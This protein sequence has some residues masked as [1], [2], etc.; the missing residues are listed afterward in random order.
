MTAR[1]QA[2]TLRDDPPVADL[3]RSAAAGDERAWE[4]IVARYSG[5]VW[6]MVRAHRLRESDAADAVATTWLRLVQHLPRIRQPEAVGAWLATTARRESLR[7]LQRDGR[8]R[9]TS[10]GDVPEISD[11]SANDPETQA[12]AND[13]DRVLWRCVNEL[14][15]R[16][17]ALMLMLTADPPATY[18]EVSDTLTMP[19]GSIGPTRARCLG[20]L[21]RSLAQA[22]WFEQAAGGGSPVPLA[23]PA[24]GGLPTS[25]IPT[26]HTR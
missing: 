15:E 6:S 13:V 16:C 26:G 1:S 23:D 25:L 17:R 8:E 21:R 12:L 14:P 11:R 5:L 4:T 2:A 3:M 18:R 20:C 22:Q 10:D 24:H 19:I 7:I 9:L